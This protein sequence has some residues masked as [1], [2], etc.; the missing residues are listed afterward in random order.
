MPFPITRLEFFR[1]STFT[2]H[3]FNFFFFSF[4]R[5]IFRNCEVLE[6]G[7]RHCWRAVVAVSPWVFPGFAGLGKLSVTSDRL[8]SHGSVDR[9][10]LFTW[11]GGG[12]RL[13]K[14]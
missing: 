2:F 7:L 5:D 4:E 12:G 8:N 3:Y 9:R 10:R 13:L 6:W 14:F 1:F 11:C